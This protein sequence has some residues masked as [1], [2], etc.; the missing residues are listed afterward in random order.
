LTC[1]ATYDVGGVFQGG[2]G[3]LS[4]PTGWELADDTAD[5]ITV[6]ASHYWSSIFLIFASDRV[7]STLNG[8]LYGREAG[9]YYFSNY[10]LQS[11]SMYNVKYCSIQ[12]M[13]KSKKM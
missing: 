7:Y 4:V 10:L 1:Q 12:I 5:A 3:Y 9:K 11:G 8:P 2:P 6:A 13:I